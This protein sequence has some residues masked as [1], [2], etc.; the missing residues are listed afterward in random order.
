MGFFSTNRR[1][2]R[3]HT[4]KIPIDLYN[5]SLMFRG[6]WADLPTPIIGLSPMDGVT[7]QPYRF[8]QKK[9]GNPDL[10]IT[11][12]TSAEG[13]AHNAN[14]LFRDF[15]FDESQRP[16]VA[17]IFGKDPAAFRTTALI[18][19]YLG[20][21]GIDIN[22]GCPA[23]NVRQS[24]SGAALIL[25]PELA[26]ELVRAV[27]AGILD[28]MN[29]KTLDD[30]PE[31]KQKTKTAILT[32]YN[33]LPEEYKQRKELPVSIKTRIG[34]D[35]SVV[36]DWIATLLEVEPVA[37]TVHGRTLK[38]MYTGQAD[39]EAIAAAVE[40]ARG[41]GTVI[42]GNGDIDSVATAQQRITESGVDG[43]LVGRAT[44]GN[45]W[46]FE[47][48]RA[49]RDGVVAEPFEP[50]PEQRLAMALEHTQVYEAAYPGESF[51]P[52]RKH[53]AW[54]IKSFPFATDLRVRLMMA[55]SG[56]DVERVLGEYLASRKETV[57]EAPTQIA[58]A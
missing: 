15:L 58:S 26:Q 37:I 16:V 42:L 21:D 44:Y 4:G 11:E 5:V 10:V 53:L 43:I 41:S 35:V 24:G 8:M 27:R 22:M 7:D 32:R 31:L 30:C 18:L 36:R 45:P 17:Q 20:F 6:F 55:N 12:F 19:C 1:V 33:A 29:G 50:T 57:E 38:Q 3:N 39:W 28:W 9:Y 25:N 47:E 2:P 46:I 34:Y 13:I 23:K 40:V 56:E 51:L 49:W 14:R 48:L 52:M 54:Y